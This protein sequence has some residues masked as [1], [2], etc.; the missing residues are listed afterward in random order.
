MEIIRIISL[1]VNMLMII[2]DVSKLLVKDN[3]F[4]VIKVRCM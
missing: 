2:K 1:Y 3:V 4:V